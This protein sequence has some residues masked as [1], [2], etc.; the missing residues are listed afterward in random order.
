MK[1]VQFE[2]QDSSFEYYTESV[3]DIRLIHQFVLR[4]A[5]GESEIV[6]QKAEGL[7]SLAKNPATATVTRELCAVIYD[8]WGGMAPPY[9]LPISGILA[10]RFSENAFD[11]KLQ[12]SRPLD[13]TGRPQMYWGPIP[14]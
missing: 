7:L 2:R 9:P 11:K 5:A 10:G 14:G 6:S 13:D 3:P 12:A 8:T 4:N 1:T